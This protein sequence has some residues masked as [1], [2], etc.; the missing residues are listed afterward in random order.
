MSIEWKREILSCD[1]I[2]KKIGKFTGFDKV[3]LNKLFDDIKN[4]PTAE[5]HGVEYTKPE[6]EKENLGIDANTDKRLRTGKIKID[7]TVDFHG[8]TLNEAFDLLKETIN[9]GYECGLRCILFITGKGKRNVDG[10]NTIK[11]SFVSWLKNP[12][13]VGKI[14]KY[15]PA[16]Q[17]DGGN[18]AMYV[19][20]RRK[21][22][23]KFI[24]HR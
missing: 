9:Y 1:K 23:L 4:K 7:K 8:K 18:G 21:S 19:L 6:L 16:T 13:I 12:E 24:L 15:A 14:I 5:N 20:L 17:K 22:V 3:K 2:N 10:A 11:K